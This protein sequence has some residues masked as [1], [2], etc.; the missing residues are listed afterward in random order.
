MHTSMTARLKELDAKE[1]RLLDLAADG[2]LPQAKIKGRLRAI[3]T[4][5]AKIQASLMATGAELAVGVDILKRGLD[6]LAD[7]AQLYR[8]RT[9]AVRRHLNRAF[10]ERLYLDVDG[11]T[12]DCLNQPFADL[13]EAAGIRPACAHPSALPRATTL[14][15]TKIGLTLRDVLKDP[16]SSKTAVV[17]L[18][19]IEPLT[20]SVT[21]GWTTSGNCGLSSVGWNVVLSREDVNSRQRRTIGDCGRYRSRRV[22]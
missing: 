15:D 5:R 3:E 1:E 18:R 11:V 22:N 9:D 17:E 8:T 19:G 4:D 6:L 20:F 16:V 7:P 21:V 13:H 14:P 12:D 10:F 2:S